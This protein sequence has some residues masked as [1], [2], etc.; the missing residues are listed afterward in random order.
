[1]DFGR[2]TI[3]SSIVLY[4]FGTPGQD[5]FGFMWDDLITGALG[6]IVL[7][8]TRR[9]DDCFPAVDYFENRDLPFVVAVNRFDGK[10]EHDLEEIREALDISPDVPVIT[11]DARSR[12]AVKDAVLVLLDLAL[13]RAIAKARTR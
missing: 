4:I 3:D 11:T 6:S 8:D 2:V 13:A 5:R 1:M 10:L 7:V 12:D 9:L